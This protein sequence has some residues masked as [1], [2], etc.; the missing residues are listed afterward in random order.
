MLTSVLTRRPTHT[1][2]WNDRPIEDDT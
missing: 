1:C 2:L